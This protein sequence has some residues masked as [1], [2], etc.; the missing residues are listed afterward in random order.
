MGRAPLT[1]KRATKQNMKIQ[2]PQHIAK[3]EPLKM[4]NDDEEIL[5]TIS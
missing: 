4:R 1:K 5:G 3:R 2:K